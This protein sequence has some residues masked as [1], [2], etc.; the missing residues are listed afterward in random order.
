MKHFFKRLVETGAIYWFA[1][2][3]LLILG[4]AM[5][6]PL[7]DTIWSTGGRYGGIVSSD[8]HDAAVFWLLLA[9]LAAGIG[10]FV[11]RKR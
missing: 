5:A 2:S 9:V 8:S 10:V 3:A 11:L 6:W 7:H 1:M 4:C